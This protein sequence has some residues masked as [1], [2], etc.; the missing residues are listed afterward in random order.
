MATTAEPL[1]NPKS[2]IQNQAY[3]WRV[4]LVVGAGIYMAT[5]GTGI[6]NVALPVLTQE[7][8]APL[9]LAQWVVLAYILCITGL[10][11]PAGR[12]ADMFGRKEVFLAGFVIFALGSGLSGL[13]PG[14]GWLIAARVIQGIGSA[15][16]Q[17]NSGA[18]V[19]Q[20]FPA[21]ERGR[22]LGMI[23]SIVSAGLLSGPMIGGIITEYVGWRWA[24]YVNVI[25]SAIATPAGWRL[26]RPSPVARGQKFDP[27]GA[28]LF[29][30]AVAAVMLGLNQGPIRGWT[31]PLTI[32]LL[33]TSV[34]TSVAFI[35]VERRVAQPTVD[36]TLFRNRGFAAAVGSGFL[37]FLALSTTILLMPFYFTLVLGLRTD[38]TGFLLVASPATVMLLAPVS[39]WLSDKFGSRIIASI[40]LLLEFA[41]FVSLVLL[42][43]EGSPLLAAVRLAVIGVGIALFNSPNSSAMFGSV[44]SSRLGLVGGFQALTRNLGQSLGQTIAGVLWS[45]VVLAVAG[46][47]VQV[48]TQA[49]PEALMAG[50]RAVFAWSAALTLMALLISLVGRPRD[51][52]TIAPAASTAPPATTPVAVTA[53]AGA[54]ATPPPIRR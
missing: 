16:V 24:F 1:Q 47:A 22:A 34:L 30:V 25:I 19:T 35:V 5:L 39:G 27:A 37:S 29:V 31:D 26:L 49:S 36:L 3:K 53:G 11:L 17:A 32:A 38:E 54:P 50:F 45:I 13:A 15:L 7:F 4:L 12:L 48:A 21:A 51:Q 10:L 18:L 23:G 43:T 42:P 9:V 33:L 46:S 8:G 2:P 52:H 6:V 20:A 28:T 41:G 14:L 40:G 44:P